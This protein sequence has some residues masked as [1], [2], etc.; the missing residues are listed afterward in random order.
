MKEEIKLEKGYSILTLEDS[1]SNVIRTLF[2]GN[3]HQSVTYTNEL[4]YELYDKFTNLY[5]VCDTHKEDISNVLVL[6]GGGFS[7]PKY[8]ISKYKNRYMDVVEIDEY[9]IEVAKK[10]FYLDELYEE[11]DKEK[12]RLNIVIDDAFKY[13]YETNK[14]YDSILV[15]LFIDN[16]PIQK[17]FEEDTL[18]QLKSIL[19]ED[20]IVTINYIITKEDSNYEQLKKDLKNLRKMF[21][22][23][24]ILTTIKFY[25]NKR[26]NI[27]IIC[28]NYQIN[29]NEESNIFEINKYDWYN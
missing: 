19:K 15:D 21:K 28:S 11:H 13:I 10:Y 20:G 14:Q 9:L 22:N 25:E 4:K 16:K 3:S 18:K 27:F 7:Y 17:T 6:G 2:T 8:Y 29:F 1:N 12:E 24:K 23:M 5:K 26:G